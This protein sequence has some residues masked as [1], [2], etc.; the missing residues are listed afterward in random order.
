MSIEDLVGWA[1]D[2]M[3]LFDE[4]NNTINLSVDHEGKRALNQHKSKMR[5]VLNLEDATI[6]DVLQ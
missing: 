1:Q 3:T 2:H 6:A 4:Y 5:E